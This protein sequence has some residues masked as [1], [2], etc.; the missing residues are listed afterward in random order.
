MKNSI[1]RLVPRRLRGLRKSTSGIAMVEF[2]MCLPVLTALGMYGIEIAYMSSVNMQ[3]SQIAVSLADN[4]SRME[5]TNNSSVTPT[6]TESDIDSVMDGAI[7]QGISF[8]LAANGRIILTSLERH[9]TTNRQ[10]MHWQRCRGALKK[11]SAYGNPTT[12]AGT[13]AATAITGMGPTGKKIAAAS[14]SAV[15][16]AEVYYTYPGVF[17]DMF[18]KNKKFKSEAAFLIRDVRNLTP[19]VSGT[20]SKSAC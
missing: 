4:A 6:V 17:G 14:N 9:P 12:Q 15:M 13:N 18:V 2:A 3:I 7:A 11:N 1:L 20:S 16:Y 10:Y 19:G 8:D 5:Q